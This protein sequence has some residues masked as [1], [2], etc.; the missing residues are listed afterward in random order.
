[1]FH[2][3][4]RR[5]H[6]V[7]WTLSKGARH[8]SRPVRPCPRSQSCSGC[9][10]VSPNSSKRLRAGLNGRL[11][12]GVDRI[13]PEAER[14]VEELR[15]HYH[16]LER[17]AAIRSPFNALDEAARKIERNPAAGLVTPRPY[18]GIARPGRAWIKAGRYWVAFSTTRPPVIVGVF[19]DTA[20]IP[21]RLWNA[22]D[23]ALRSRLLSRHRRPPRVSPHCLPME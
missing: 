16:T 14:Q 8:N 13:Y 18:P 9:V 12:L 4:P 21:N 15:Q 1:M 19:H 2:R 11:P 5:P 22:L 7:R 20:D 10:T 6:K 17:P 3:T 23:Y